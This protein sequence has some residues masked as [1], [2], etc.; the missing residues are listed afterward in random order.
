MRNQS[1]YLLVNNFVWNNIN[2]HQNLSLHLNH[3]LYCSFFDLRYWTAWDM[4]SQSAKQLP[5]SPF[6]QF[7]DRT[8]TLSQNA[9]ISFFAGCT[10]L[11]I[12]K[13]KLITRKPVRLGE[14]KILNCSAFWI[15]ESSVC[16]FYEI[17]YCGSDLFR[18]VFLVLRVE[19]NFSEKIS[20][21]RTV[22]RFLLAVALCFH[23]YGLF[24]QST[25]PIDI[26]WTSVYTRLAILRQIYT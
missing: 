9:Q 23:E 4:F 25:L 16:W 11:K 24:S 14:N 2:K 15:F 20:S 12:C 5:S 19:W 21:I 26:L 6:A 10:E 7:S 1:N 22:A 8:K 17:C 3:I 13:H 18:C